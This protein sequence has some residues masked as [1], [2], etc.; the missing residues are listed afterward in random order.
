M[1][2]MQSKKWYSIKTKKG[3]WNYSADGV[4]CFSFIDNTWDEQT[5]NKMEKK[6]QEAITISN[7]I[8]KGV[9]H[10]AE[11]D[12]LHLM[13]IKQVKKVME[14]IPSLQR[15]N[16][17]K[18]KHEQGFGC[19]ENILCEFF[20]DILSDLTG[21]V[22][23]IMKYLVEH[24]RDIQPDI[25]SHVNATGRNIHDK[26]GIIIG[27]VSLCAESKIP[28]MSFRH[29][30]TNLETARWVGSVS[31]RRD[32]TDV[33]EYQYYDYCYSIVTYTETENY[34]VPCCLIL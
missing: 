8:K 13:N 27:M 11:K 19:S 4:F 17:R 5:K 29:I 14:A 25:R 6:F 15:N 34:F 9:G 20:A 2:R 7:K 18:I 12:V 3:V 30:Y 10:F 24:I 22:D 31:C 32:S 28:L 33:T 23:S 21:D 1:D 16:K 26:I